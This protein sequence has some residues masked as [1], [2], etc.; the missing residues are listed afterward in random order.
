LLGLRKF[1]AAQPRL[2]TGYEGVKKREANTPPREKFRLSE[3]AEQL[4]K[5]HELPDKKDEAAKWRNELN[6]I[7]RAEATK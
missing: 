2:P 4:V 7:S 6:G 3:A 1:A 5:L